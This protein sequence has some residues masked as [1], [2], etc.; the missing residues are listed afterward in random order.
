M[1]C[2]PDACLAA[3]DVSVGGSPR[4]YVSEKRKRR[5][6]TSVTLTQKYSNSKQGG[7]NS[8]LGGGNSTQGGGNSTQ[9]GGNSTHLCLEVVEGLTQLDLSLLRE[10]LG[11]RLK[12][13][14]RREECETHASMVPGGGGEGKRIFS[15]GRDKKGG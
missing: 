8:T 4:P 12:L 5:S 14:K 3:R 2:R 9:G 7:G 15:K 10:K 6:V 11:T 1:G 13:R